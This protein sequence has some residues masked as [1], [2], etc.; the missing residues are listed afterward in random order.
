MGLKELIF[1]KQIKQ[2]H[3]AQYRNSTQG[4]LPILDIQDGVVAMKDGRVVKILEIMPVNFYLKSA[5]EQQNIIYYFASYLKIAPDNLQIKVVTQ[6]ADIAG[7]VARM[8]DFFKIESSENCRQMIEDNIREVTYLAANEVVTRRF[9]LIFQ[10]EAK[11]KAR[12]NTP[13]A[14]A[15]RLREEEQTARRYLDMCGLEVV[16]VEY[17]DNFQLEL[18]YSLIN[19]RTSQ[20]TR[21]P[22]G[23]YDMISK[24]HGLSD[25]ELETMQKGGQ[26]DYE[27]QERLQDQGI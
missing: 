23:V 3:A 6:K 12:G 19:K 9:F 14:I 17:A 20:H 5:I 15:E 24:V 16:C 1:G 11:M 18:L 13:Q 26:I 8:R 7:Y 21:L 22:L 10:Y 4:W 25:N 27:A 2:A